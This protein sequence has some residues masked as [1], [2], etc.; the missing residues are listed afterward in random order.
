L[1][2]RPAGNSRVSCVNWHPHGLSR[3]A[4]SSETGFIYFFDMLS[5]DI[6]YTLLPSAGGFD[7]GFV[8]SLAWSPHEEA[9]LVSCGGHGHIHLWNLHGELVPQ[10]LERHSGCVSSVAWS[11]YFRKTLASGGKDGL[12]L[13]W[14]IDKPHEP[15]MQFQAHKGGVLA[16]SWSLYDS[17]L[18]ASCGHDGKIFIWDIEDTSLSL[19][20]VLESSHQNGQGTSVWTIAWSPHVPTQLVSG[21]SD[22]NVLVWDTNHGNPIKRFQGHI[23]TVL[24]TSWSPHETGRIMSS[25]FDGQVLFWET[26]HGTPDQLPCSGSQARNSPRTRK[27]EAE[28][29]REYDVKINSQNERCGS[30]EGELIPT[31]QGRNDEQMQFKHFARLLEQT[32]F[33][34]NTSLSNQ[35]TSLSGDGKSFPAM[36]ELPPM[37]SEVAKFLDE[38]T[39]LSDRTCA[40]FTGM[41]PSCPRSAEALASVVAQPL[42]GESSVQRTPTKGEKCTDEEAQ[43]EEALVSAYEMISEMKDALTA[44]YGVISEKDEE[45]AAAHTTLLEKDE[46]LKVASQGNHEAQQENQSERSFSK[47]FRKRSRQQQNDHKPS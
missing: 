1:N 36:E 17:R 38:S 7:V 35:P 26:Q 9:K 15:N 45:L 6:V 40:A 32:S 12:V 4:C 43:Q 34:V 2:R 29:E 18:L 28:L 8:D 46:E 42:A 14:E 41:P 25:S 16:I 13:V 3:L 21:G 37:L 23:G 22:G 33:D 10:R 39:F 31:P 20:K 5:D 47:M 27:L 24:S 19:P 44:A 30:H 11:P